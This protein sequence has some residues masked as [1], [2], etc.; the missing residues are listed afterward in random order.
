MY[1]I[2]VEQSTSSTVSSEINKEY[3]DVITRIQANKHNKLK[4]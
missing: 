2:T 4:Q 1:G 3:C